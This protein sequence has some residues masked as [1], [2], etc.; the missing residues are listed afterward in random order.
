MEEEQKKFNLA[1]WERVKKTNPDHA[2]KFKGK[3]GFSGTAVSQA[4]QFEAA[5][6]EFGSFGIGW[7]VK[8]ERR[9]IIPI[10]VP[11]SPGNS[12][13][14]QYAEPAPGY[15]QYLMTYDAVLWYY[16]PEDR[17]EIGEFPISSDIELVNYSKKN[18][19][20][21]TENDPIKKVRTDAITKG[22][23]NLGFNADLFLGLFDDNK[24]VQGLKEEF[25]K[26][27]TTTLLN[28]FLKDLK[29]CKTED[30]LKDVSKKITEAGEQSKDQRMKLGAAYKQRLAELKQQVDN[31]E[32]KT[33]EKKQ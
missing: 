30:E 19:A 25:T 9:E 6:R 29:E 11:E 2:K 13:N 26:G 24:Y 5:T 31:K 7:G 23:S 14:N 4:S 17:D 10:E 21:T 18:K 1:L 28:K 20:F 3:G 27:M 12:E 8:D 16:H 33:N 32:E 22:L 15:T